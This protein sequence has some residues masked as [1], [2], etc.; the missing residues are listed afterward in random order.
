M[1][2][3]EDNNLQFA[4]DALQEIGCECADDLALVD[5]DSDFQ[6]ANITL[7]PI[8][9]KKLKLFLESRHQ[10]QH[11][12]KENS[13]NPLHPPELQ[14]RQPPK[15]H[16]LPEENSKLSH[17]AKR[18]SDE[19]SSKMSRLV[20]TGSIGLPNEGS[21]CEAPGKIGESRDNQSPELQSRNPPKRH[22]LSEEKSKLPLQHKAKFAK[23]AK[24][25]SDECSSKYSRFVDTC[26]IGLPNEGSD[27]EA[28]RKTSSREKPPLVTIMMQHRSSRAVKL[29]QHNLSS[30]HSAC[31]GTCKF[32]GLPDLAMMQVFF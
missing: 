11:P 20:D 32:L 22:H 5:I 21:D 31:I 3:L 2:L 29:P 30:I 18:S 15:L 8:H 7:K 26:P 19:C 6:K 16:H 9:Y 24:R 27:C 13:R 23:F 4:F 12:P 10:L 28:A 25:S 17:K 14:S 1:K